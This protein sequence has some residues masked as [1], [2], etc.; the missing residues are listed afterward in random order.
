MRGTYLLLIRFQF[1]PASEYCF[2]ITFLYNSYQRR[3]WFAQSYSP[4]FSWALV[5]PPAHW[6]RTITATM[7]TVTEMAMVM[8]TTATMA[9]AMATTA[10]MATAM[11]TTAMAM[12]TAKE[13][14]LPQR[15]LRCHTRLP[16]RLLTRLLT[17]LP[18]RPPTHLPAPPWPHNRPLQAP[19]SIALH[20]RLIR[21]KLSLHIRP[22]PLPHPLAALPIPIVIPLRLRLALA[23][24]YVHRRDHH[25]PLHACESSGVHAADRTIAVDGARAL[26]AAA[27]G[28][29]TPDDG[30]GGGGFDGGGHGFDGGV[31]DALDDG[32]AA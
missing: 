19:P 9:M 11:A 15:H 14:S 6:P 26:C 13:T 30:G 32:G 20:Q 28:A 23:I 1:A 18:T 16:T 2:L 7:A 17:R 3:K 24:P 27:A 4:P 8:A 25:K 12:V 31:F 22:N 21:R 5:L 10:T 29:G